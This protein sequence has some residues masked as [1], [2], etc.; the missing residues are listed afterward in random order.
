MKNIVII[1]G[2][3]GSGKSSLVHRMG[4]EGHHLSYDKVREVV[5]GDT[6]NLD[7]LMTIPQEH[8]DLVRKLTMEALQRRMTTGETIVFE[9]TLPTTLHIEEIT[10]LAKTYDY[11]MLIVDFYS[12]RLEPLLDG[13]ATRPE[14]MRVKESSIHRTYEAGRNIELPKGIPVIHVGEPNERTDTNP[15]ILDMVGA[16]HAILTYLKRETQLVDLSHYRRVVHI[17]DIQGT[18][19]PLIDPASPLANGIEPDVFYI[20]TGDL[21]DRG[22]E[23]DL[24]ARWY[25]DNAAGKRNVILIGGNHEDHI[26]NA[27]AG[28]MAV[29]REWADYT[30]PQLEDAGITQDDMARI[31]RDIETMIHYTWNG[32]EVLVTHG[33]LSKFPNSPHLISES[34]YRRG[35]GQY[36]HGI[37]AMWSDHEAV[38]TDGQPRYQVHGHRNNKLLPT[39]AAPYSFNLE[40]QVEFGGHLRFAILDDAGWETV[41]IRSTKFRTM[42][43]ERAIADGYKR[44]P[45]GNEAPITP[46]AA[47]GLSLSEILFSVAPGVVPL[48]HSA[49]DA[50]SNH[51]MIKVNPSEAK[52][53]ISSINFTKSAFY[54]KSWDA[55]TT[56][57][58]GLFIDNID[59]S[60]VARSYEKFFNHGERPDTS[61]EQLQSSLK[62]PIE[63]FD[64]SNG[65]LCI[66]GYSERTGELIIASKSR[67]DGTFAEYAQAMIAEKLGAAGI[68]RLLRFNRDQ[69][70][71]LIFEVV[72]MENDPHIIDY[73]ESKLILLGCVRRNE[74]FEQVDYSTLR[75]IAK[76]LGCEVKE[77]TF[78]KIKDWAALTNIMERVENDPS[79]RKDNPTEGIVFQDANGFQW[80]S[81]GHL[82]NCWKRARSAI[83]RIALCRRRGIPF[84]R[85]RFAD[86]PEIAD[87][88]DWA[89]TL[90]DAAIDPSVGIIALRDMWFNDRAKAEGMG[91]A[92]KPKAKNMEGF[93]KVIDTLADQIEAGSAKPESVQRF[94]VSAEQDVDKLITLHAHPR[95]D[96][97]RKFAQQAP[98]GYQ[99]P[100]VIIDEESMLTTE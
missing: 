33:G 32:T 67:V 66:T 2:P 41:D 16:A 22:I 64:K 57:A 49:L 56:I 71:S 11:D 77:I 78:P 36:G 14:R 60:I 26:E 40:G 45:F 44:Q 38:R 48:S 4:L 18:F 70:A 88:I 80:K 31:T 83:E 50:L 54:S 23:N 85:E 73:P 20:F 51:G 68:E 8:N 55:Y 74:I 97:L 27:A 96:T 72:D 1:R 79:W 19:H 9:A 28:R 65:F 94:L 87:F 24:V 63:G 42:Q 98:G 92:P 61:D 84:D 95:A 89:T 76:W 37:D 99:E 86:S 91:E 3:Q 75:K 59:N 46:W 6:Y 53:H 52:P 69:V 21:F 34:I 29:S 35:N 90:P 100:L 43:E 12:A 81:K 15:R 25:L 58:R 17:G 39:H 13:N 5:A 10:D 30:W 93:K 7:G 47:R 62:F 82:Y